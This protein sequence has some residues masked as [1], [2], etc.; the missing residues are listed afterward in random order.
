M[1]E[2]EIKKIINQYEH[3]A[4]SNNQNV[5]IFM[6]TH[7]R[8]HYLLLAIKSVLNQSFNNFS[9]IILDNMSKDETKNV[10]ESIDDDRLFYIER[11]NVFGNSSF[12]FAFSNCKTKYLIVFHDDDIVH[13][14]YLIRMLDIMEKNDNY[15]LLS[16]SYN[17]IDENNS[18]CENNMHLKKQSFE[19]IMTYRGNEFLID[20]YTLKSRREYILFPTIIYRLS[21]FKDIARF[22][23]SKTGPSGDNYIYMQAERFGGTLA[24]NGEVLFDY[25]K[26]SNQESSL[27]SSTMHLQLLSFLFSQKYYEEQL[28]DY[29]QHFYHIVLGTFIN[30]IKLFAKKKIDRKILI[31][32][33][34]MI[35]NEIKKGKNK[36]VCF[37]FKL[38]TIFPHFYVIVLKAI[39]RIK[40]K[41]F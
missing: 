13:N 38:A 30:T 11:E 34:A 25:R 16:C 41:E 1:N 15:C 20:Y 10:I 3:F 9:L 7:K 5:T 26:H 14:D 31:N 27:N 19:G 21:F 17:I 33:Y 36:Q 2:I 39:Y 22:K 4:V 6:L 37:N 18:I 12:D 40:R 24:I 35:P 32:N 28:K 23:D 29:Y 8:P